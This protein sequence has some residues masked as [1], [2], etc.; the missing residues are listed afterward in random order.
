MPGALEGIRVLD[1]G[2][3]VQGPQ[4]GVL[5]ADMGADVIKVELPEL[6]DHARWI[7]ISEDDLRGVYFHANN[8]G[9]RSVTIDLRTASGVD[10][11]KRLAADADVVISNFKPG[12]MESWG[13]GYD[14]LKAINPG[15]IWGAGSTFGP[16]GPDSDRE[17][18]DLAGQAAGGLVST[19][20]HDGEPPTPVGAT[21][22]D[23]CASQNLAAGVL[24]ALVSRGRTGEGQRVDVSLLGGQIWAQ[25]SEYTHYLL[26]GEVPGRGTYGHPLLRGLYGLFQTQDGWIGIIGVPLDDQDAFFIAIDQPELALDPR[27]QGLLASREDMREL[28]A[29]LN[30][31]FATKTTAEWGEIFTKAGVRWAPVR[32][33]S[34]VAQDAGA[35]ENGY[36]QKLDDGRGGEVAVVPAPITMTGTPLVPSGWLPELGEHTDEVLQ[37][38]GY[39]ADDIAR[40]R[41]EGAV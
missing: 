5:L 35:W 33:Y 2:L 17:G 14:D 1:V 11:F 21:I 29:R 18:A 32:D 31:V 38:A 16:V 8:R 6:G 24:A 19:I 34:E 39:S 30:P 4:A 12:T 20:G 23:H 27:Y 26:T 22:A 13:V 40:F 41:A 7:V 36:F 15:I 3:L 28:F 9:K 37:G 25:A 10:I